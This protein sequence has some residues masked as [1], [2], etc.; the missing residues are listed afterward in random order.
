MK[1]NFNASL[2]RLLVHEGGY[3]NHPSDPGGETNLGITKRTYDAYRRGKKLPIRSV[4]MITLDET[5]DIYKTQYW[6]KVDGD[7]LPVGL[8]YVV[9]DGA[10]NSGPSQSIKWLQRA[11]GAHYKGQ[12]DGLIGDQTHDAINSFRNMDR[13]IAGVL[14]RR[15]AFMQSLTTWKTFGKGWSARVTSVRKTGQAWAHG[16]VG[17]AVVFVPSGREKA[18]LSDAKKIPSTGAGD[19]L[20]GLGIGTGGAGAAVSE[21][22]DALVPYADASALARNVVIVLVVAGAA[23]SIGG[24]V[25]RFHNKRKADK[26]RD[27][28]DLEAAA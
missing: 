8:D 24:A 6:D 2:D 7:F 27:A 26:L 1:T 25:Y 17:P 22:R 3:V 20:V 11:L 28:L 5:R 10:V 4:R 15:L 13:L 23:I 18:R 9:F 14:E 16:D 19:G 21:A 12:I